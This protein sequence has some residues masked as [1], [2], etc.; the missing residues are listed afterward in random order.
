M[1]GQYDPDKYTNKKKPWTWIYARMFIFL[2]TVFRFRTRCDVQHKE[3]HQQEG[4]H[5][6]PSSRHGAV[7]PSTA[8]FMRSEPFAFLM[9]THRGDRKNMLEHGASSS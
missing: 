1:S 2:D 9:I 8:N 4:D 3:A 5:R 7:G 6:M